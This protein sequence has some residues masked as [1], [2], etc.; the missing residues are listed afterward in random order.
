MAEIRRILMLQA[1]LNLCKDL[2]VIYLLDLCF[3]QALH[4]FEGLCD[5]QH[6][7]LRRLLERERPVRIF[8]KDEILIQELILIQLQLMAI[9]LLFL[10]QIPY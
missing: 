3:R 4:I 2:T 9:S 10:A 1:K 8:H 7:E 5:I 6:T